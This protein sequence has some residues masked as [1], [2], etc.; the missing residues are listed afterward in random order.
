[1]KLT[2]TSVLAA[3]SL[4]IGGLIGAS[5]L[6]ALAGW[7]APKSTPPNCVTDP[8]NASYQDGCVTPINVGSASQSKTGLFGLGHFQFVPPGMPT[9]GITGKVLTAV[10][11]YG[12]V[13]WGSPS[14]S[15][16]VFIT[17]VTVATV[18]SN[19]V[20][21]WTTVSLS[22]RGIPS[23]ASALILQVNGN[24]FCDGG[25]SNL[26]AKIEMRTATGGTTY[27]LYSLGDTGNSTAITAM[28][29]QGMYPFS[30]GSMSFDYQVP[31]QF[32]KGG[33]T[34]SIVGYMR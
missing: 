4:L 24:F 34:I 17:P 26:P 22:G 21:G 15:G 3:S 6:V 29:S 7:D 1:M 5:T 25:C 33:A 27:S 8:N 31:V 12:T 16:P 18:P 13:G 23:T 19:T 9:S 11:D 32:K 2:R 28:T 14:A 20:V 30:A 10:D